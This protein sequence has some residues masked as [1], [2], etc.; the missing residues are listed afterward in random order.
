MVERNLFPTRLF[1]GLII[2]IA[3]GILSLLVS[4]V[5]YRTSGSAQRDDV[6]ANRKVIERLESL[7]KQEQEDARAARLRNEENQACM[8]DLLIALAKATEAERRRITNPCP[9][10][11]FSSD[12]TLIAPE[13]GEPGA[14]TTTGYRPRNPPVPRSSR[15][16]STTAST[17]PGSTT[18]TARPPPP[19]STVVS[20]ST[21]STTACGLPVC[22]P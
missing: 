4:F 21:T 20:S 17:R 8:I 12:E 1:V 11:P 13:S 3:I 15:P 7:E 5:E 22:A 19:T 9:E 10:S 2:A 14:T 16:T 18:T 6:L